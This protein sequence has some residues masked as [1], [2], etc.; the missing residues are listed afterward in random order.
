MS[1]KKVV[2]RNGPL[3]TNQCGC[4]TQMSSDGDNEHRVSSH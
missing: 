3:F 2:T 1:I 4:A